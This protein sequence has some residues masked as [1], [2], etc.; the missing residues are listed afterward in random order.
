MKVYNK[1]H[2]D[3][4]D[5]SVYIGRPSVWGNPFVVGQ[6]GT[7]HEVV[8]KYEARLAILLEDPEWVERLRELSTAAGLI[9]FCA[10]KRC[11]GDVL[12]REMRLRGMLKIE[13]GDTVQWRSGGVDQF[14]TPRVVETIIADEVYGPYVYVEGS[15]TGVPMKEVFYWEG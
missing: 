2:K 14:S 5:K 13:V 6:D 7:R 10:P 4:P 15:L 9:C 11:H 3:A 8:E 12:V 1:Y